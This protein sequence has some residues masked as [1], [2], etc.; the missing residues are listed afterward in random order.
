MEE[1]YKTLAQYCKDNIEDY[2]ERVDRALTLIDRW[3][4]PLYQ[5][6]SSLYGAMV[7]MVDEWGEEN[8]INVEEV[9]IEELIFIETI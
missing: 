3:R 8:E 7:D 4:A 9:D 2:E 5:V 1:M 6:D